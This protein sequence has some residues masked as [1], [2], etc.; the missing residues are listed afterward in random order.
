MQMAVPSAA[1]TMMTAAC[2]SHLPVTKAARDSG[3]ASVSAAVP[4]RTS[5]LTM[6]P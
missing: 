6:P 1:A 5:P 2:E 3:F 4:P